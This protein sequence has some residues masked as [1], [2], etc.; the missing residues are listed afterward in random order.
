MEHNAEEK[1]GERKK[2][3]FSSDPY[4]KRHVWSSTDTLD[5]WCSLAIVSVCHSG[6]QPIN[7][8]ILA[9]LKKKLWSTTAIRGPTGALVE[10]GSM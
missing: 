9:R 1:E 8:A 7:N 10:I 3:K 2:L 4:I 5:K 6:S